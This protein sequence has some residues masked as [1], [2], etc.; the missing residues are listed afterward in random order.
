MRDIFSF[1]IN[2]GAVLKLRLG[3]ESGSPSPQSTPHALGPVEHNG[4]Y[5][6]P[7]STQFCTGFSF[8]VVLE[9]DQMLTD[10]A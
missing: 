2:P 9:S 5:L 10:H 8:L 4:K 6:Y 3:Q 7:L 1:P